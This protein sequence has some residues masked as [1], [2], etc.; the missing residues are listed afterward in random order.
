MSA[1]RLLLLSCGATLWQAAD[2][3]G[4]MALRLTPQALLAQILAARPDLREVQVEVL[5]LG[6]RS[7]AELVWETLSTVRDTVIARSDFPS[8][9]LVIG[10]DTLDEAAFSL[11]LLLEAHM[12][13]LRKCLVLTGAMRPSDQL[14]A[15][16][17]ANLA[18]ALQLALDPRAQA[19]LLHTRGPAYALIAPMFW[20]A[21]AAGTVLVA[22]NDAF[23]LGSRVFKSDSQLV[24][25][26]HSHPGPAGQF[27]GGRPVWAWE[28]P[29]SPLADAA[30]CSLPLARLQSITVAI[31]VVTVSAFL[32]EELLHGLDGLVLAAPGTGSLPAS[33]VRQLAGGGSG[34]APPGQVALSDCSGS[35]AASGQQQPTWTSRLSIVISSRCATGENHD[36]FYYE[37]SR[38][39]YERR[40]FLLRGGYE[41]LTPLQARCLLTLRLAAF[42][43]G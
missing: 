23:H 36:D 11:H 39:K 9:V 19:G 22:M 27:R 37:G 35:T 10:T 12:R 7:G 6:V 14:S 16:G 30:F 8:Y 31:W 42:G 20:P 41:A 3:R 32:P 13:P 25:A 40:G 2:G 21:L 38:A 24:G 5:E 17:P 18:Q 28:P 15:D 43:R 1:P 26:F 34:E 4:G 29:P 33:L